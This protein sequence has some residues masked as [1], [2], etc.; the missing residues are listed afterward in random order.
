MWM[1]PVELLCDAHLGGEHY[2]IHKLI[3]ALRN[4]HVLDGYFEKGPF[5][6]LRVLKQRHDELAAELGRRK[7]DLRHASPVS[8][9]QCRRVIRYLPKKYREAVVDQNRSRRDLIERCYECRRR[10]THGNKLG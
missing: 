9:G 5:F 6:E 4:R 2:E 8:R 3:G 7:N 10:L 1:L